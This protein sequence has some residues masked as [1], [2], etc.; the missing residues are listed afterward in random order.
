MS[1]L[2]L[3]ENK[4]DTAQTT[5]NL[6]AVPS[7]F[8][9]RFSAAWSAGQSPDRYWNEA[10]VRIGKADQII[11]TVHSLTGER[12][13][14]PYDVNSPMQDEMDLM[15]AEIQ[16]KRLTALR[17]ATQRAR[18]KT[19]QFGGMSDELLDPDSI[20]LAVANE[21]RAA[22]T[23]DERLTGT[24]GGVGA[25]LGAAAAETASPHGIASS[26]IPVTRMGGAVAQVG[27]RAFA[28]NVAKEAAFQGGAAGAVQSLGTLVDYQGRK[29]FGTEQ[30][31]EQIMEEIISAAGG[32]AII[33]GAFRA[34]H[35]GVLKL[36]SRGVDIPEPVLDR[37]R[38]M[39]EGD[40]YGNKNPLGINPGQM[41][42]ATDQGMRAAVVGR[43][44]SPNVDV[45]PA[46]TLHE[47]ARRLN[48]ELMQRYDAAVAWQ[49]E[50]RAILAPTDE[51][52]AM[53]KKRMDDA[54]SAIAN[55]G[56][57]TGETAERLGATA[58][59]A[60]L[61]HDDAVERK[62]AIAAQGGPSVA[63]A[64]A[65][66]RMWSRTDS[67][68]P[69]HIRAMNLADAE[70]TLAAAQAGAPEVP[71][72]TVSTSLRQ[73]AAA[74]DLELRELIPEINKVMKQAGEE[75]AAATRAADEFLAGARAADEGAALARL[76]P[77]DLNRVRELQDMIPE[78]ERMRDAASPE[79]AAAWQTAI[80]D[81]NTEIA[82]IMDLDIADQA[83]VKAAMK[84]LDEVP[85][86]P[87]QAPRPAP[88]EPKPTP[89]TAKLPGESAEDKAI[90]QSAKAI[91][92]SD[93]L[94]KA[95]PGA[96]REME[97]I[98]IQERE[99]KTAVSCIAGVL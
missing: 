79:D 26:F 61:I 78:Y 50:A 90:L 64:E 15:P 43:A 30:T 57:S 20:D 88:P 8:G 41:E 13:L 16:A 4:A 92:D 23:R 91:V 87:M 84:R 38:M 11:D 29:Q 18:A 35:L 89:A 7:S 73:Q 3:M 58:R 67:V 95:A 22:R 60:R 31:T 54:D 34:I 65:M 28:W 71:E 40:L 96:R 6:S 9:E 37:A 10:R 86:N 12:P 80:D 94:S 68:V 32:G 53:L 82:K 17:E 74:A 47:A 19:D 1:I 85:S 69:E 5:P 93:T 39:E 55:A 24:G 70:R 97:L 62:A 33:G 2:G 45:N 77:D 49:A 59:M 48:P 21:S 56:P 51:T 75:V 27:L 36:A 44:A 81:F 98:D 72:T 52:I 66:V 25:F 14:N 83:P 99:Y 76:A 42:V 63:E 46:Q